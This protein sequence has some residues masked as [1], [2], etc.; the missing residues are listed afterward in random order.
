MDMQAGFD[1]HWKSSYNAHGYDPVI[2]QFYRQDLYAVKDFPVIDVFFNMKVKSGRIFVKYN[3]LMQAFTRSGYMVTP[4]YPGQR[5]TID[6]G[7][8]LLF[9]D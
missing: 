9:Y 8:D 2:Q 1:V 5:N 6:F 4:F 7:F 3:N